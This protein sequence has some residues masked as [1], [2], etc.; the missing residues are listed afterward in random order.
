MCCNGV[1][2]MG[3]AIQERLKNLAFEFLVKDKKFGVMMD[4]VVSR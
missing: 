4:I 1:E 3:F 2:E